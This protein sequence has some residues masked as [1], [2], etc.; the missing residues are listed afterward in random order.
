MYQE[1]VKG[2]LGDS[3]MYIRFH[4]NTPFPLMINAWVKHSN[5]MKCLRVEAGSNL[6]LHSSVG[7]WHMDSMLNS[8]EDRQIWIDA[9]LENR[10]I[11]GKFRSSP[12][13]QGKYSWMEYYE[14]FDCVYSEDKGEEVPGLIRFQYYKN[15]SDK[16]EM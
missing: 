4:N 9:G 14:P 12:C 7:E 5:V 2:I 8:K 1:K 11:I 15:K 10:A 6:I 16:D 3:P 13:V